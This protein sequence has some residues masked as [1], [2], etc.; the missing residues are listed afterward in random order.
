MKQF[1]TTYEDIFNCD[2]SIYSVSQFLN[3]FLDSFLFTSLVF[4]N[5][6]WSMTALFVENSQVLL[7]KLPLLIAEIC[8][9]ESYKLQSILQVFLALIIYPV[10]FV[11]SSECPESATLTGGKHI[12]L[13]SSYLVQVGQINI[14]IWNR[15]FF[16][17]SSRLYFNNN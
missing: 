14:Y 12:V 6:R 11:A 16:H 13:V 2:T 8:C 4:S 10:V 3:N 15:F 7:K 9:L 1:W 17:V 5:D